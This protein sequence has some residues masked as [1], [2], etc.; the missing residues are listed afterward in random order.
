MDG[1]A[2]KRSL[3]GYQ[4]GIKSGVDHYMHALHNLSVIAEYDK[5]SQRRK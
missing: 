3:Q 4:D 5:F 2:V 1:E